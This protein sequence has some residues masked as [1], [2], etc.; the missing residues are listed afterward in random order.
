MGHSMEF[1]RRQAK[2]NC[3]EKNGGGGGGQSGRSEKIAAIVFCQKLFRN[4]TLR[5][6]LYHSI[7]ES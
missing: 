2:T 1:R 6:G 4:S 3:R 5:A 7:L